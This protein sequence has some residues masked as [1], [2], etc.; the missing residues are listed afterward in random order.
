VRFDEA[1]TTV[2]SDSPEEPPA[3]SFGSPEFLPCSGCMT[4][5][6]RLSA[7][8]STPST[9]V[10]AVMGRVGLLGRPSWRLDLGFVLF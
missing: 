5:G 4:G 10:W 8:V 2:P 3:V 1:V 6:A 7:R 9:P